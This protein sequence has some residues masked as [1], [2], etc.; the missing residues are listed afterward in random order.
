MMHPQDDKPPAFLPAK[1]ARLQNLRADDLLWLGDDGNLDFD[2]VLTKIGF[3][4][5]FPAVC[6][7]GIKNGAA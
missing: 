2:A 6:L 7:W 4:P 5:Q 1:Q 3:D